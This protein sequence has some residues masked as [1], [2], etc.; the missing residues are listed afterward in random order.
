VKR[1][2]VVGRERKTW[3]MQPLILPRKSPK[4]LDVGA[5]PRDGVALKPK[6]VSCK[7]GREY[8]RFQNFTPSL[9]DLDEF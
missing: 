2:A 9:K 3:K 4:T 6:G 7:E 8:V 5:L 1:E